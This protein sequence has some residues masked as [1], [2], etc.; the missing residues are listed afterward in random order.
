MPDRPL[1]VTVFNT[2]DDV[3]ELLRAL[4]EQRGFVVVSAHLDDIKRGAVVGR[5][6]AVNCAS[7]STDLVVALLGVGPLDV[8]IRRT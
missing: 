1:T 3:V 2:S 6:Y 5:L 4:F 8:R 7:A